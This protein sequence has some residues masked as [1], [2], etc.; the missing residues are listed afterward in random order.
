MA[1]LTSFQVKLK[2]LVQEADFEKQWS[3]RY[4]GGL[5]HNLSFQGI[6]RLSRE[7]RKVQKTFNSNKYYTVF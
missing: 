6:Y 3:R 5:R 2:L 7:T 4:R 1:F